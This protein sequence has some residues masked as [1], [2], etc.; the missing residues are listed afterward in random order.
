MKRAWKAV[1]AGL[2]VAA[3]ASP[4]MAVGPYANSASYRGQGLIADGFGGYDLQTETCD[5]NIDG[6]LENGADAEGPYLL[7]VLTATGAKNADITFNATAGNTG[8]YSMT[9]FGNGTFK[10]IS[11]WLDPDTLPGKASRRRTTVKAKDEAQL[12]VSHGC[13]PF[14]SQGAWVLAVASGQNA[15]RPAA[16]A[17]TG[18]SRDALVQ[19]WSTVR[20]ELLTTRLDTHRSRSA[21]GRAPGPFI[22]DPTLDQVLNNA[23]WCEQRSSV[24]ADST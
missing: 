8:T 16:W 13:R 23:R 11:P 2:F 7:F 20:A 5:G 6:I 14:T 4:A 3:M 22:T 9:K 18:I 10:Y 12:V 15:A 21:A 1:L 24:R 17:L 19:R